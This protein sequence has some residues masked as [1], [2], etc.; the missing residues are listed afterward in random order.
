MVLRVRLVPDDVDVPEIVNADGFT[1]RK[2]TVRD[3][4]T[5][6]AAIMSNADHL[7]GIFGHHESWPGGLTLERNLADL[8][9]HETEFANRTSFCWAVWDT[10]C[11]DYRGCSY[12]YPSQKTGVDAEIYLWTTAVEHAKGLD[13]ALY[14]FFQRWIA[15]HWQFRN[16][17]YPGRS[18]TWAEYHARAD[19]TRYLP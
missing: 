1:L 9:W 15:A 14:A 6:F 3:V 10:S 4:I 2:L 16:P 17:I 8:G 18:I 5:D 12:V 7:T 11:I 13:G 19:D